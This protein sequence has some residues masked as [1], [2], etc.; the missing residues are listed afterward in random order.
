[1]EWASRVTA[2]AMEMVVPVVLGYWADKKWGT[3]VVF[4]ALGGILG[5]TLGLW[6]LIRLARPPDGGHDDHH[7][8]EG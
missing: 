1:M 7:I 8:G 5:M 6:N 2:I 3:G 4:V